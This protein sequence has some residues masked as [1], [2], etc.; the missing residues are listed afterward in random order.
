MDESAFVL[1]EQLEKAIN[2]G[3]PTVAIDL[4][5]RLR[6]IGVSLSFNFV[7][8]EVKEPD[9][10]PFTSEHAKM[11]KAALMSW[12]VPPARAFHLSNNIRTWKEYDALMVEHRPK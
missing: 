11:A 2:D 8:E 10:G 4:M 12:G 5:R 9:P 7:D 3:K 1:T 6:E